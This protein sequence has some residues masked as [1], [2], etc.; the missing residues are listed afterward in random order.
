MKRHLARSLHSLKNGP[1]SAFTLL[2][3]L[4][5]VAP[6]TLLGF[7]LLPALART[8]PDTRSF[9]CLNNLRQLTRAWRMYADDNNDRL[10]CHFTGMPTQSPPP[11]QLGL[12]W[13]DW[14]SSADNTNSILLT[15]PKSSP[16]SPYCGQDARLFKCPA[17]Q[18]I[19]PAQRSLGW[20]ERVRSLAGNIYTG[21]GNLEAGP[22]DGVYFHVRKGSEFVNPQPA[23]TW[24]ALDEHPDSINDSAFFAPH[25]SSWIDLPA[26]Y[27]DGGAGVAFADGRA[28]IHRW[29]ASLLTVTVKYAFSAPHVAP[30]DLDV[31]WMMYHTPRPPGANLPPF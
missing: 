10:A 16:L 3:L 17:D 18:F 7:C 1:Q 31:R 15:D 13:L 21:D 11:W 6:L 5:I 25:P 29:Q 12:G 20:K 14:T 30:K 22:I 26:N 23:D 8:K 19:S 28:E 9:Q 4:V 2:E 27:H 24:V